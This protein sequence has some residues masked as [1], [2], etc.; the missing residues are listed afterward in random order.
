MER[1]H[2]LRSLPLPLADRSVLQTTQA[3]PATGGLFGQQRQR[4]E[5][6]VVDGSIADVAAALPGSFIQVEPQLCQTIHTHS[7]GVV[8]SDR[9]AGAA[10]AL[11]DSQR[12][13]SLFRPARTGLSAGNLERHG[14]ASQPKA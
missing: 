1:A 12:Q 11:W 2:H 13:L 7:F 14:T 4:R 8:E 3:D 6:A 9:L 10:Q 5:V